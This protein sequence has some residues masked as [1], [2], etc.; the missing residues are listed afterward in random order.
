[1]ESNIVTIAGGTGFLGR[2]VVRRLAKAGFRLRILCRHPD[3]ALHLKTAGDVGQIALIAAD[4]TKPESL[5]GKL[6]GC[7]A[8]I[9]LTG[10]LYE[11]GRQTFTAV[12]TQGAE[13]L[14]QMARSSGAARFLHVSALGIDKA[15][16]SKYARSK[17]L[18]EK[19][20]MAAF[21]QATI[22]RPSVIFG[23]ED[24]FI[25]LF[26]QL[27][28]LFPA[29]PLIGGGHTRFQPV[30]VD[31][32]AKA[33]HACLLRDDTKGR[34]YELGGPEIHNFKD[35]LHT[36]T[37]IT[38]RHRTLVSVPFPAASAIGCAN[39]LLPWPPLL[40]RDQVTL[41]HYDNVVSPGVQGFHEL[42][43]QPAAMDA[44]VPQYLARF[45]KRAKTAA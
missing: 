7:C 18:G 44:V 24:N 30:Y 15:V 45:R 28:S 32:V 19:A 23:P 38:G 3:A 14:A 9:N 8:V 39:E 41:L 25:N 1:M 22:L 21:P 2:Y 27:A 33:L 16:K 37:R 17:L 13:R 34:T 43:I 42:G 10:I 6:A 26:A 29:L 20:V 36:I 11:S 12:H 35:I 4:V 31:D 5:E 40:T